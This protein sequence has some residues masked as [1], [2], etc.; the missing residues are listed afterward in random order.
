MKLKTLAV[1]ALPLMALAACGP[2]H[3]DDDYS[4][5]DPS[6]SKAM[7]IAL[8]TG[9]TT[10]KG[11]IV[12]SKVVKKDGSSKGVDSVIGEAA[13]ANLLYHQASGTLLDAGMSQ[14]GSMGFSGLGLV[15][16][17]LSSPSPKPEW[18]VI[19]FA[20]M[21]A[22]LAKNEEEAEMKVANMIASFQKTWLPKTVKVLDSAS[23]S[24][25]FG[26]GYLKYTIYG[27][28][29]MKR[30]MFLKVQE[31]TLVTEKDN[32]IS[33]GSFYYWSY[34]RASVISGGDI[35]TGSFGKTIDGKLIVSDKDS[36]MHA[37]YYIGLSKHM[38]SWYYIYCPPHTFSPNSPPLILNQG[39]ALLFVK[40]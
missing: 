21:P 11:P 5:Y 40:P 30:Q 25:A 4:K 24:L 9:L 20:F 37:D 35:L 34:L 39:K 2:K 10:L 12:D 26:G 23:M 1:I 14:F 28:H 29:G 36:K 32:W 31:P 19:Q 17:L 6:H 33:S 3:I 18:Q 16:S 13:M 27:Y 15:S 38:P 7:N 22:S 8:F